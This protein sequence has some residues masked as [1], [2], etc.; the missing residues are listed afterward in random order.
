MSRNHLSVT[1]ELASTRYSFC[2]CELR[3]R[4]ATNS[5][6]G[7]QKNTINFMSARFLA[8]FLFFWEHS[9]ITPGSGMVFPYWCNQTWKIVFLL[10]IIS[11]VIPSSDDHICN[12]CRMW[13]WVHLLTES[14]SAWSRL[15]H[16]HTW[17]SA[18]F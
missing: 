17:G 8:K 6:C 14:E 12:I 4:Q 2:G 10:K 13:S 7:C 5:S 11:S 9:A 1:P 16:V 15:C 3:S 18:L